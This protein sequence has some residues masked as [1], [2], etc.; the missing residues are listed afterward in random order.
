MSYYYYV[1]QK[2]GKKNAAGNVSGFNDR[3]NLRIGCHQHHQPVRGHE[4][5]VSRDCDGR[6]CGLGGGVESK[7]KR[8]AAVSK[9]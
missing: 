3:S 2:S 1:G 4:L 8:C 9:G 5:G 6:H 7:K